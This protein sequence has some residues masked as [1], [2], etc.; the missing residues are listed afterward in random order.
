MQKEEV[1]VFQENKNIVHILLKYIETTYS[2]ITH[3][4]RNSI[5]ENQ[6]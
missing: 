2:M 3:K 1:P 4:L 5:P 6:L